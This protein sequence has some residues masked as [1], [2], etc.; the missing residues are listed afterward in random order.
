[1]EHFVAPVAVVR[2]Q[3]TK[4]GLPQVD[5]AAHDL[6]APLQ[7]LG[8]VP[9]LTAAFATPTAHLTYA[10][11]RVAP[12]QS[13]CASIAAWTAAAAAVS[14]QSARGKVVRRVVVVVLAIVVVVV[15]MVTVV[16]VGVGVRSSAAT[17]AAVS[18][19]S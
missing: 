10:P 15:G 12:R 11:W 9:A 19:S 8:R 5:L 6:T 13:H 7:R 2:Q 1:M 17:S 3:V 18:A 14:G 4:P 16:V